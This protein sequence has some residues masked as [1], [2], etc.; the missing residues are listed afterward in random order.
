[1]KYKS[2]KKQLIW[3]LLGFCI[4]GSFLFYTQSSKKIIQQK[5]FITGNLFLKIRS[6]GCSLRDLGGA[7][8]RFAYLKSVR[9]EGDLLVDFG[10]AFT[11]ESHVKLDPKLLSKYNLFSTILKKF[12]YDFIHLN[13]KKLLDQSVDTPSSFLD[14]SSTG[15]SDIVYLNKLAG[16]LAF[17]GVSKGARDSFTLLEAKLL[18]VPLSV[19]L[20]IFS[21]LPMAESM[22]LT[23]R[24]NVI[25]PVLVIGN[26]VVLDRYF[27]DKI[28]SSLYVTG[29]DGDVF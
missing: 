20:V 16:K 6:C 25:R 14:S 5:F 10:G 19:P 15:L 27:S 18:E 9:K 29:G 11:E 1:M 3:L 2:R 13:E 17:I 7:D 28:G 26:D 24:L 22:E 8:R 12:E 23:K 21:Y 4:L